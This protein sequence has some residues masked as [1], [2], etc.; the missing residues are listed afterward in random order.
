MISV[1][2]FVEWAKKKTEW[3]VISHDENGVFLQIVVPEKL[4]QFLVS[5]KNSDNPVTIHPGEES[6]LYCLSNYNLQNFISDY[7]P[8]TKKEA[9]PDLTWATCKQIANELKKRKTLTFVLFYMEENYY[10]NIHVEAS[11]EANAIIGLTT[12]GLDLILRETEKRTK[13]HDS[14]EDE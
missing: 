2:Q 13:M 6:P 3:N 9:M 10:D 11:G 7:E 5:A 1:Q 14:S 8:K 12:R 4:N